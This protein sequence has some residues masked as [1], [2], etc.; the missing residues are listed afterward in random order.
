MHALDFTSASKTLRQWARQ[1][2]ES[3]PSNAR[4]IKYPLAAATP[5]QKCHGVFGGAWS[6]SGADSSWSPQV[7][8]APSVSTEVGVK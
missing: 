6:V 5:T 3:T 2:I 1:K 8:Q 4:Q 7:G